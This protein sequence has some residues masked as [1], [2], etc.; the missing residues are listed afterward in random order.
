MAFSLDLTDIFS[1][2]ILLIFFVL[3]FCSS[4]ILCS[5]CSALHWV[6][7]NLKKKRKQHDK[8]EEKSFLVL[9]KTVDDSLIYVKMKFLNVFFIQAKWVFNRFP[10]R[11]IYQQ[12]WNSRWQFSKKCIFPYIQLK[13]VV[14]RFRPSKNLY[15]HTNRF[16]MG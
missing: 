5:G 4:Y 3:L 8:G 6:N 16:L 11:C 15:D 7:P 1:I 2:Y 10:N 14:N 12:K 9:K 13:D